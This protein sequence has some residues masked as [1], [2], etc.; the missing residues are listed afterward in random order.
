MKKLIFVICLLCS[1]PISA[2]IFTGTYIQDIDYEN[3]SKLN[4]EKRN[5]YLEYREKNRI[6][7][8]VS[9]NRLKVIVQGKIQSDTP[10]DTHGPTIISKS[11]EGKFWVLYFENKNTIQTTQISFTRVQ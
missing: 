3:Y 6:T 1:F 4:E 7:L 9:S 10:F 8:Q 11:K 5:K 2:E